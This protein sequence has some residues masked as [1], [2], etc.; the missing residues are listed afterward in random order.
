M[1]TL[2]VVELKILSEPLPGLSNRAVSFQIY[3]LI[4]H[5]PPEA[6]YEHIVHPTAFAVH[7]DI[8]IVIFENSNKCIRSELTASPLLGLKYPQ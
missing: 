5:T 1:P 7:A 4:F 8:D 3:I 6:L 2:A